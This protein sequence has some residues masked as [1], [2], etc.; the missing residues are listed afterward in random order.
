MLLQPGPAVGPSLPVGLPAASPSATSSHRVCLFQPQG[1]SSDCSLCLPYSIS[2]FFLLPSEKASGCPDLVREDSTSHYPAPFI[3]LTAAILLSPSRGYFWRWRGSKK[4]SAFA[5]SGGRG[6]ARP[7]LSAQHRR[8]RQPGART[9]G[10]RPSSRIPAI[11][12]PPA[13]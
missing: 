7:V 6:G 3:L 10:R 11:T 12:L 9:A 8:S 5:T 1:L 13:P 4:A 2:P